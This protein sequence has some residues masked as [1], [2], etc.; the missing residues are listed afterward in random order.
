MKEGGD[1]NTISC[2]LDYHAEDHFGLAQTDKRDFFGV[3]KKR[4]RR[5][6][7]REISENRKHIGG[8]K[9]RMRKEK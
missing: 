1:T 8:L 9:K 7:K 2:V 5:A 6:S 3:G 4:F